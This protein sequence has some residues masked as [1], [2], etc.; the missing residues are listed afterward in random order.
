MFLLVLTSSFVLALGEEGIS[1]REDFEQAEI[2][3]QQMIDRGINVSRIN[4]TYQEG[5][6][7]YLSQIGFEQAGG[8]TN[9]DVVKGYITEMNEIYL[10]ALQANDELIIFLDFYNEVANNVDLSEM[11]DLYGEIVGSFEGERFED[12]SGLIDEGYEEISRIQSEQTALNAFYLS[13]TRNIR[14]FLT[15]YGLGL[16]Y[17][18]AVVGLVFYM[19]RKPIEKY[20]IKVKTNHLKIQKKALDKLIKDV[21][22]SYFKKKNISETEYKIK[23]EKFEE[24]IRDVD[25]QLMVLQEDLIRMS[26][27]YSRA[28]K[29]KSKAKK[30]KESNHSALHNPELT[31]T[32]KKKHME[33]THKINRK[34]LIHDHMKKSK[35]K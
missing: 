23:L 15:K 3:I 18:I 28:P 24:I 1:L 4:E 6:Q 34:K 8:F 27:G 14:Y 10:N 17:F 7:L 16:L 13:T 21:Q 35:K 22:I 32:Q 25:R 19:F 29:V 30:K 5:Y 26:R 33:K 31:P 20:L 2:N 9:Y 11:S 12:T